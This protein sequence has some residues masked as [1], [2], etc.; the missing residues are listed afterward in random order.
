MFRSFFRS[1]WCSDLFFLAAAVLLAALMMFS[2]CAVSRAS[3]YVPSVEIDE[4][5]KFLDSLT[6]EQ[7][8][9]LLNYA[10]AMAAW[11]A[12]GRVGPEPTPPD[13]I[14]AEWLNSSLLS[15]ARGADSSGFTV[16][17]IPETSSHSQPPIS[18]T[19]PASRWMAA[20]DPDPVP[21]P[22]DSR[23]VVFVYHLSGDCPAFNRFQA[24]FSGLSADQSK[25]L[26]V[27]FRVRIDDSRV[28]PTFYFAGGGQWWTLEGWNGPESFWRSWE[29]VQTVQRVTGQISS[30]G[31]ASGS[32]GPPACAS[33]AC[34]VSS[35][36]SCSSGSCGV[37]SSGGYR[38]RKMRR[39]RR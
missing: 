7:Q 10:Q 38:S 39:G 30:K 35:S 27:Q 21:V 14:P 19:D 5:D 17:G 15:R 26:P 31:A 4:I 36:G 34:G 13:F 8:I 33:G 1:L 11:D 28:C 37:S 18:E 23:P 32:S 12:G 2:G 9:E 3:N 22:D 16:E 29:S 24:W 25:A 20:A 6:A